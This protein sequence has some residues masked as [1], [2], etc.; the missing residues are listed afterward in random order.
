MTTNEQPQN[1]FILNDDVTFPAI[2]NPNHN[3]TSSLQLTE[4]VKSNKQYIQ[5]LLHGTGAVLF[6]GFS[7]D[8]AVEFNEVVEC[9]GYEDF[10]YGAGGAGSRT[11]ICGRVYTANESPPE[12]MIGFHHELSHVSYCFY[13]FMISF[14]MCFSFELTNLSNP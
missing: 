1:Q 13:V 12:Q 4:A 2:L 6:R 14:C 8:T 9:F 5:S 3:A 11:K 7:V 10:V